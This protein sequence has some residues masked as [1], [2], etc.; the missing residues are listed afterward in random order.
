MKVAEL[1]MMEADFK[2]IGTTTAH[3]SRK[4]C[5]GPVMF[6][7]NEDAMMTMDES[8]KLCRAWR[9]NSKSRANSP[10]DSNKST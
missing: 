10:S 5:H 4:S 9:R 3:W 8:A 2:E 1:A 6:P 7:S